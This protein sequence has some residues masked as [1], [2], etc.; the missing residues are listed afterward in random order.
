MPLSLCIAGC[1]NY[2]RRVL[3]EI[4]DMRDDVTLY[5]ASRDEAKARR[6]NDAYGGAGYFGTY[7]EAAQ[8][9]RVEAMYLLL[10]HHLHL[11]GTRLA[12]ANSKHVLVEK[13]IARTLPEASELIA[14]ARDAGV[15]LMVAENYRFAYDIGMCKELMAQGSIGDIRLLQTQREGNSGIPEGWRRDSHLSG[16]GAMIDGGIHDVDAMVNIGG[17]PERVY[18]AIPPR[19][20]PQGEGEDGM[21][22]TAQLPGGAVGLINFSWRTPVQEPRN[23]LHVTGT[24][25]EIRIRPF[26]SELILETPVSCRTFKLPPSRMGVRPMI[27]EFVA[28]VRDGREPVMSGHEA[29]KDLAVVLAAYES[30]RTGEAVTPELP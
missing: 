23:F 19:G 30:A 16:G 11:E 27:A 6:F 4:H 25:G 13:P 5:F 3:D 22:I 26:G 8:D 21:T 20:A 29:V 7:E 12:A 18:A 2:A 9:P 15:V 28:A 1:G 14:V 24:K 10:P 17:F